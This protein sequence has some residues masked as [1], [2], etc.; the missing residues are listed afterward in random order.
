MLEVI[1]FAVAIILILFLILRQRA[2]ENKL[3][4][5]HARI[6]DFSQSIPSMVEGSISKTFQSSAPVFESLFSSAIT[7]NADLI[8]GAFATSLKELGIQED[9]GKLKEASKDLKG[10]SSDLKSMFQM[11]M[12]R[13]RF[14][15]LQLETLLEDIFPRNRLLFQRNIGVGTPDACILIEDGRYLCI[16]SKFPLENFR[17]YNEAED[18]GEKE[19]YWKEFLKDVRRHAESIKDKYVGKEN[20]AEFAFMFVPSDA[21]FYQIVSEASDV[22]VEASK[23]GVILAS[24]SVLPAYLNL[25]SARI[26]AEEISEKAEEIQRKMNTFGNYL[27]DL[28]GKLD[29]LFRHINNA[30]SNVP[31]VQQSFGSLKAYYS[32]VCRLEFEEAMEAAE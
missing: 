12:E 15:E 28:G 18:S 23:A 10:I 32:S 4:N 11:K 30:S 5:F 16:D 21:L 22:A 9:L 14:G 1:L 31:K 25:V 24:P 2:V 27:E 19:K 8:K 3:L 17:K 13:A 6:D 26:R 7:K 20:T 29:T